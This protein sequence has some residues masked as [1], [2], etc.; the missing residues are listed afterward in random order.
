[1]IFV[2]IYTHIN[3]YV[4]IQRH[5]LHS[6][7]KHIRNQ[8]E[9]GPIQSGLNGSQLT[10]IPNVLVKWLPNFELYDKYVGRYMYLNVQIYTYICL[11]YIYNIY[12]IYM[13][14]VYI[15]TYIYIYM[16][17][18]RGIYRGIFSRQYYQTSNCMIN[19]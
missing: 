4:Y 6:L 1:M 13:I 18:Y 3:I 17:I 15:Y 10:L 7:D 14:Y 11:W 5:L 12:I 8:S 2:Y 19:M 9:L 16:Y